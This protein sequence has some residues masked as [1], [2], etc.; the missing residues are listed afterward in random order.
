MSPDGLIQRTV[1]SLYTQHFTYRQ[2][3]SCI[4]NSKY[5]NLRGITKKIIKKITGTLCSWN[6]FFI[7]KEGSDSFGNY[8]EQCKGTPRGMG[9]G[10]TLSGGSSSSTSPTS[11]FPL[12]FLLY[13]LFPNGFTLSNFV[14]STW[15]TLPPVWLLCP[16]LRPSQELQK[17]SSW[18][19]LMSLYITDTDMCACAQ[20]CY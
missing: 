15:S 17:C 9:K 1:Q 18:Q 3:I 2:S 13:Q 7:T 11:P 5:P 4:F 16:W 6:Q 8:T 20:N 12:Y 10:M 14:S 19:F